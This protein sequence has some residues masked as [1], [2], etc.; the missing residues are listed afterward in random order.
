MALRDKAEIPVL[1]ARRA[2]FR[3]P[4][5]FSKKQGGTPSRFCKI[6]ETPGNF[7]DSTILCPHD[8]RMAPL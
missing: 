5:R 4:I 6:P 1:F 2:R 8:I 3:G 7:F